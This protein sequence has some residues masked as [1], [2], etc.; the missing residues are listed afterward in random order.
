[1]LRSLAKASHGIAFRV[2][3][4][5]KIQNVCTQQTKVRELMENLV[6]WRIHARSTTKKPSA[7]DLLKTELFKWR[8]L[9]GTEFDYL[10]I[11][12]YCSGCINVFRLIVITVFRLQTDQH[13]VTIRRYMGENGYEATGWKMCRLISRIY[14][15]QWYNNYTNVT[16]FEFEVFSFTF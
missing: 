2:S 12:R 13:T 11:R 15:P 7:W 8:L 4:Y 5:P 6:V 1:M 16:I 14:S 3:C 10:Y 9:L